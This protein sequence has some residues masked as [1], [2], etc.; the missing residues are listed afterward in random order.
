MLAWR[1]TEIDPILSDARAERDVLGLVTLLGGPIGP[2]PLMLDEADGVCEMPGA[3]PKGTLRL[4][5]GD[6]CVD[7]E[8]GAP[9]DADEGWG[10]D[11]DGPCGPCPNIDAPL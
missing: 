9:D 3:E 5:A 10:P 6:R 11:P 2:T 8:V 7:G 1:L 4:E